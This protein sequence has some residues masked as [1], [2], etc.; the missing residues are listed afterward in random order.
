ML[1]RPQ[2][3]IAKPILLLIREKSGEVRAGKLN[4]K[5]TKISKKKI[6]RN[7]VKNRKR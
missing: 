7:D 6:S 2:T 1:Y 5:S 4:S 3:I